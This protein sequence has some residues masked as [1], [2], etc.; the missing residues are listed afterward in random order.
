MILCCKSLCQA[1]QGKEGLLRRLSTSASDPFA[2]A[3][4]FLRK[5]TPTVVQVVVPQRQSSL[6]WGKEDFRR[7]EGSL[8]VLCVAGERGDW[9]GR[10]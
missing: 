2:I 3:S 6:Q 8:R 1:L 10:T 9:C 5:N 4:N 7:P